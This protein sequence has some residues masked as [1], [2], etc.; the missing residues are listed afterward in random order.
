MFID[1]TS[2]CRVAII[3]KQ[4]YGF[5]V[6]NEGW[7]GNIGCKTKAWR[8]CALGRY[9]YIDKSWKSCK[10]N[11]VLSYIFYTMPLDLCTSIS[12]IFI[13]LERKPT[14]C[15]LVDMPCRHKIPRD[16]A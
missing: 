16:K 15:Q 10:I 7:L 1:T 8:E 6:T 5:E 4:F 2:I 9:R 13:K 14:P 12:F 11:I 3:I